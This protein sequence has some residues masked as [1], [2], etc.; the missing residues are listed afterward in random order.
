MKSGRLLNLRHQ[1]GFPFAPIHRVSIPNVGTQ[2]IFL[3]DLK[4]VVPTM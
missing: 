3:D 4:N 2:P 1:S